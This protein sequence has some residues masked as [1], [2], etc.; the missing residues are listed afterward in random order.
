MSWQWYPALKS[1]LRAVRSIGFGAFLASCG[2]EPTLGERYPPPW[3][4]NVN[5]ELIKALAKNR[6]RGCGEMWWRESSRNAG[7]YLVYCT[8]DGKSWTTWVVWI[9]ASKV[10]G[11]GLPPQEI[12]P[13]R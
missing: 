7:E 3:R 5:I 6:V 2:P 12:P 1:L 4:E 13:P 11:P 10:L 9:N 8:S